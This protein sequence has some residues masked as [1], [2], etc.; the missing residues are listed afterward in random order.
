[1]HSLYIHAYTVLLNALYWKIFFHVNFSTAWNAE[2][3]LNAGLEEW[4]HKPSLILP[5]PLFPVL[6]LIHTTEW[7]FSLTC[8]PVPLHSFKNILNVLT[9]NPLIKKKK[10]ILRQRKIRTMR[11]YKEALHGMRR[12]ETKK[13]KVISST[14]IFLREERVKEPSGC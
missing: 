10:G 11:L 8:P 6:W 14:R 1:M 9:G 2:K 7:H 13:K 12:N 4:P 3:Y 5:L